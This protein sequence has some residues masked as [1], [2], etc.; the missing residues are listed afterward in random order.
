MRSGRLRS[1]AFVAL[2]ILLANAPVQGSEGKATAAS[3]P[4]CQISGQIFGAHR[5]ARTIM[6]KSDSGELVNLSYDQATVFVR[7]QPGSKPGA[8]A[9]RLSSQELNIGDRLC[10]QLSSTGP[11]MAALVRVT[12]HADCCV[13]DK[14]E[15]DRLQGHSVFGVVTALDSRTHRLTLAAS[16]GPLTVDASGKVIY[17]NFPPASAHL[18]DA[19]RGSWSDLSVGKPIYIHGDKKDAGGTM[20]ASLILTGGWRSFAGAIESLDALHGLVHLRELD[21]NQPLTVHADFSNLYAIARPQGTAQSP[22]HNMWGMSFGDLHP[23]DGVLVLGKQGEG[24]DRIE[25]LALVTGF[26]SLGGVPITPGEEVHWIFDA[27]GLGSAK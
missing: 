25:G 7:E 22:R 5:V 19:V 4:S 16:P 24:T 6:V 17:W 8:K 18:D 13:L 14:T 20:S 10:V 3:D 2:P 21:S 11:R 9:P 1:L 27:I 12:L 23:G 15:L 26:S